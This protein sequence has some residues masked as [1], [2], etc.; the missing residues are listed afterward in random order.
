MLTSTNVWRP[1]QVLVTL[2][3][4][5][6]GA[7]RRARN[8]SNPSPKYKIAVGPF[9]TAQM[10]SSQ[11]TKGPSPWSSTCKS[12]H[13]SHRPAEPRIL[14]RN[15]FL[16]Q[17]PWF[18]HFLSLKAGLRFHK[19]NNMTKFTMAQILCWGLKSS[20]AA[21]GWGKIISNCGSALT[22]IKCKHTQDRVWFKWP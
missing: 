11:G 18:I 8:P 13:L 21:H 3:K 22:P 10:V 9:L 7:E 12:S 5:G 1:V 15:A 19:L 16:P 14:D 4:D 2:G 6:G 17:L 20:L